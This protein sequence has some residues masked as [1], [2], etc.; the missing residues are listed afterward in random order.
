MHAGALCPV[1]DSAIARSVAAAVALVEDQRS[2]RAQTLAL[3]QA[4]TPRVIRLD[5]VN[6][7]LLCSFNLNR[8]VA[9][10]YNDDA[11]DI[12]LVQ[13][14]QH[15]GDATTRFTLKTRAAIAFTSPGELWGIGNAAGPQLVSVLELPPG[16]SPVEF[17]F[18]AK[19]A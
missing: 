3:S 4:V 15:A 18:L 6:A 8:G 7:Q 10:V 1:L 2:A 13:D 16:R 12:F 17:A 14:R 5:N 9:L 11:A 19:L